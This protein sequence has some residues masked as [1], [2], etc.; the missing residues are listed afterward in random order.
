M[1]E[2]I[3]TS[4]LTTELADDSFYRVMGKPNRR[5]KLGAVC[6]RTGSHSMWAVMM[7]SRQGIPREQQQVIRRGRKRKRA[8]M[9]SVG[10]KAMNKYR[11][12][13]TPRWRTREKKMKTEKIKDS[14]ARSRNIESQ[15]DLRQHR[16]GRNLERF[17]QSLRGSVR[18]WAPHWAPP[19]KD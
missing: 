19:I 11:E 10:F 18:D 6:K 4:D 16:A 8:V 3:S 14:E 2:I 12:H 9:R 7:I 13:R 17:K 5:G 15:V 1:I